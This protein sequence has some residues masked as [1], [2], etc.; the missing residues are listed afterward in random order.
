MDTIIQTYQLKKNFKKDEVIKPLDFSLRKGEICALIGKNGA[1]KSTIFKMLAGQLFPTS[2]D[3][4]LFGKSGREIR[5]ARKRMGF[6]IETP[7]FFPDFTAAKNLEYFRIQRGVAEKERIDE[8]LQ[9]VGLANEK[10]KRFKDYSTGMKQRLGIA[11]CLLG[12]PDCLVLDEPINGLDAEGIREIRKLLLK[13]NKENQITILV[14]SHILTELQLLATRFVF[15]KN[16]VIVDDVSKEA[17]DEKSRKQMLFK[18]ND[19]AKSAQL[20]EQAYRDIH[21]K[22]LPDQI[23]TIQNHVEDGGEIN[24]LFIDNG[25]LV[26]EFRIET[27]NLEDYFLG[28]V[29]GYES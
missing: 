7:E 22:I 17:L 21:Y 27:L 6:M 8:V 2:G 19:A 13:L 3:I 29:E 23:I 11:L 10:K 18:V 25:V 28:L 12:S 24:R 20:L 4:Q 1:G 9:I 5:Q 15:I 14:S 16:G 26:M